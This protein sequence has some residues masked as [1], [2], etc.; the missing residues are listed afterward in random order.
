VN[1]SY[2]EAIFPMEH[3]TT[4]GENPYI[5]GPT[6]TGKDL[7]GREEVIRSILNALSMPTNRI[8]VLYGQRRMGKTSVLY[9]LHLNRLPQADTRYC[10]VFFD[11]QGRGHLPE[12]RIL[13]DL[14]NAIAE[15]LGLDRLPGSKLEPFFFEKEFLPA[16]LEALGS[17]RLVCLFDEFDSIPAA[18]LEDTEASWVA[19]S[20]IPSFARILTTGERPITCVFAIG[21]RIERLPDAFGE[22]LRYGQFERIGL[23]APGDARALIVK[24]ARGVITYKPEV[25]EAILAVTAGHPYF[26]QLICFEIFERLRRRKRVRA[27]MEDLELATERALEAGQGAFAWLWKVLS[28]AE[29]LVISTFSEATNSEGV[30]T[31]DSIRETLSR[32]RIKLGGMDLPEATRRLVDEGVLSQHGKGG[33]RFSVDLVRRWIQGEHPIH[34]EKGRIESLSSA[35]GA[36]YGAGRRQYD[37]GKFDQAIDNFQIALNINPNHLSAQL[38]L[39]RALRELGRLPEAVDAFEDAFWLGEASARDEL[40]EARFDLGEQLEAQGNLVEANLHFRRVAEIAPHDRRLTEKLQILYEHGLEVASSQRWGEAAQFFGRLVGIQPEF[41]DA[42]QRL[43]EAQ[44]KTTP[45]PGPRLPALA[46]VGGVAGLLVVVGVIG[47]LAW[48]ALWSR[49]TLIPGV[50]LVGTT[51]VPQVSPS[52]TITPTQVVV[53][54]TPTSTPSPGVEPSPTPTPSSGAPPFTSTPVATP[55]PSPPPEVPT[56]TPTSSA[57]STPTETMTATPNPTPTMTSTSSQTATPMPTPTTNAT[58]TPPFAY[59]APRLKVPKSGEYFHGPQNIL[60]EWESVGPLASDEWYF[61]SLRYWKG[62][63]QYKGDR[64]KKPSWVIRGEIFYGEADL[65]SGRRYEWDVTVVRITHDA[66]GKEISTPLS[67][68]SE[69]REFF[70]P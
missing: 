49:E 17:R 53:A 39:A 21:R 58:P 51:V 10:S 61:V 54:D 63:Y 9:E 56:F 69:T 65:G 8:I 35:A 52:L 29:R 24:P 59:A 1:Y 50:G 48:G 16:A 67:P 34:D 14:A 20:D 28:E 30:A 42:R 57:T 18:D 66:E 44:R 4:Q 3:R 15:G 62:T 43:E 12:A 70:W 33:Y 26:T 6:V 11:F 2:R 38:G 27:E 22:F 60:L 47:F 55:M 68:A 25:I 31:T 23:L 5:A 40:A 37:A 36:H 32:N 45:K 13:Y 46:W 19:P 7:F 41:R 64:V